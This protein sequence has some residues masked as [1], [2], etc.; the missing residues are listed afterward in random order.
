LKLLFQEEL[1]KILEEKEEERIDGRRHGEI[2]KR[3][4]VISGLVLDRVSN[5]ISRHFNKNSS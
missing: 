3:L 5:I 1:G 4:Q 2:L